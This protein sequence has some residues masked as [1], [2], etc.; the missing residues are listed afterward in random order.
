MKNLV[1]FSTAINLVLLVANIILGI[2]NWQLRKLLKIYQEDEA[3]R[4]RR[5]EQQNRQRL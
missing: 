1:W 2:V 5:I 3:C 4:R